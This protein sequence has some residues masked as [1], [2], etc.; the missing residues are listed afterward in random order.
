MLVDFDI[1]FQEEPGFTASEHHLP[2]EHVECDSVGPVQLELHLSSSILQQHC[3][4]F[5][6]F[7]GTFKI[8]IE[9]QHL[10]KFFTCREDQFTIVGHHCCSLG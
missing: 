10:L 6:V 4:W 8:F 3:Q 9:V 2:E 1:D 5:L 7:L